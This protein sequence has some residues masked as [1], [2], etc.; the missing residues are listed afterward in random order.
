MCVFKLEKGFDCF[1]ITVSSK[2]KQKLQFSPFLI[3]GWCYFIFTEHFYV[4][5]GKRKN[6]KTKQGKHFCLLLIA[7]FTDVET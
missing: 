4:S 6:K 7:H 2:R 3:R 5:Y 1:Y